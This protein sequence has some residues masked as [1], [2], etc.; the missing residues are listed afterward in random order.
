MWNSPYVSNNMTICKLHNAISTPVVVILFT[1]SIA[2]SV[3]MMIT[4]ASSNDPYDSGYDHGCD[5]A[6]ILVPSDRYINQ[7]EKGPSFHTDAFMQGYYDGYD[8]CT[9]NSLAFSIRFLGVHA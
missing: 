5:D 7:P 8:A 1:C 2:L 4:Y 9:T 6:S 3:P